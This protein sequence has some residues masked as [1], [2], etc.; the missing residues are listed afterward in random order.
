M[1]K[2]PFVLLAI[3]CFFSKPSLVAQSQQSYKVD[4]AQYKTLLDLVTTTRELND[5]MRMIIIAKDARNYNADIVNFHPV[6]IDGL[7]KKQ[8]IARST[9]GNFS[10]CFVFSF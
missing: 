5:A 8:K 1:K 7:E 4:S 6:A 2:L 10:C 9:K 3:F